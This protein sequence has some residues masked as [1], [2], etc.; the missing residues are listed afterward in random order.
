MLPVVALAIAGVGWAFTATVEKYREMQASAVKDKNKPIAALPLPEEGNKPDDRL[1]QEK[2]ALLLSDVRE[3]QQREL[4]S[5]A[6][7]SPNEVS[8]AE[9]EINRH[10]VISS[11][12]LG[13]ATAGTLFY[14]PLALL[15]LPGLISGTIPVWKEAYRIFKEERRFGFYALNSIVLPGILLTG[16]Y[17]T[18]SLAYVLYF[19]SE[20]LLLKTKERS[21]KGLLTLFA[22]QPHLVWILSNGVEVNIPLDSLK[23]GDILVIDA[24]ETIP[25]DGTI[26]SGIA[27]IDERIL[28][29]ESQ[30]VEKE[31]GEQVFASTIVLS[32]KLY[33][34]VEK[35]GQDTIAAQI[36][37]ILQRT[38]DF[39]STTELKGQE[40]ANNVALPTFLLAALSAPTLGY[41][42]ALALMSVSVGDMI[43]V[44]APITVLSF[45]QITSREGI[46]VKDGRAL[47]QLSQVDTIVF[48]KTGTLTEEQPHVGAIYTCN[49]LN[50]DELLTIAAAAEHKQ[51]HPIAR[52]IQQEAANRAL[53]LPEIEEAAYEIGYGLKVSLNQ[54]VV[55]VGSQRFM[56]MSDIPIPPEIDAIQR[57][58]NE[59]G[60]SLVYVALDGQLAGA[61]EL[62]ATI[63]PEA[64]QAIRELRQKGF[65]LYILSG[66]HEPPTKKLAEELEIEHYFSQTL[67]ENKAHLIETLQKEGKTVCFVG[68]GINDSIA[69]KKAN[70]S[71]SLRKASTLAVD[72]ASIILMN[73]ELTQLVRLIEVAEELNE[74]MKGNFALSVIPAAANIGGVFLFNFGIFSAI[75]LYNAG[76]VSGM[77]NGVRPLITHQ[78]KAQHISQK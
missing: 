35:T 60:N 40:I 57:Q 33:I 32:G 14:P 65:D 13:L 2:P 24:G 76:L 39:T 63:R 61:I 67:P 8:E 44:A 46:L 16:Y 51:S 47:E 78:R 5:L 59:Y 74:H 29:G 27:S 71:I 1:P 75:M 64:K 4:A 73:E 72:T 15:S 21:K 22:Q 20:K 23:M 31:P 9:K 41:G 30:P 43:R 77:V 10:I 56:E 66:D 6:G 58:C 48:D 36:S 49:G 42:A 12:S 17:F 50:E 62:H 28:T 53:S 18:A 37:D 54:K 70:V 55:L 38:T 52:A 7:V 45:L 69:L 11:V 3:Q 34:Q 68:D 26:T 19:F 25:V